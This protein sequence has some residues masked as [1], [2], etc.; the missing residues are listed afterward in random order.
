MK[1]E[2]IKIADMHCASC[3]VN[4]SI[5]LKKLEGIKRADVNFAAG[6]AIV[7]YDETK[8]NLE[9][10][11]QTI[12]ETG[13][14]IAEE[15]KTDKAVKLANQEKKKKENK[16]K[17]KVTLSIIFTLPIFIRMF[18][19]WSIPG[20]LLGISLTSWTQAVLAGV[21]VFVFG[22]QFHVTTVKLIK[23]GQTNM[24][25]LISL[26]TLTAFFY[27]L[28]AATS[29]NHMYFESAATITS[30]I[31]LGKFLELKSKNRAS[32]AMEKLMELG[33]KKARVLN[34]KSEEIETSIDE[35]KVG[36]VIL[37]KP[38]EKIP[39]DG[40]VLDGE[41]SV[42][43][44][45]LTGESM[46]VNK[47]EKSEVYGATI[48]L[49]G[50][51]K[52]KVTKIGKDTVLAQIIKTVEEAQ[53]FKAPVQRLADKISSIFVPTVVGLSVLTFVGWYMA[54]QNLSISIINAVAVL[55]ISCPCALGIA[56]PIAVM[57]GTSVGAR[58]GILIK[59][60]ESFEK[61]KKIDIVVFDKTGTL[62]K[63]EP[64]VQKIIPATADFSEAKTLKIAASL[65]NKSEH[66]LSRAIAKHAQ[67]ENTELAEIKNFQEISGQGTVG[68][69]SE[70]QTK[71]L[72]GNL[73]L[74]E[75]NKLDTAWAKSILDKNKESGSTIIFAAHG[76]NI[77]G[78][79]LLADKIKDNAAEA[80]QKIK[81]MGLKPIMLSGDNKNV[82]RIVANKLD[83]LDYLAEILPQEKQA[84]IKKIQATNKQVVFVGDG[85]N[86]APALIQADLG[87]AMGSGTDIAK[88]SGDIIIMKNDPLKIVDALKLSRKTFRVIKQNL[89]W[90]FFYNV[91]AIPLAIMGLVNPMVG[92]IAMTFSD[93]TVIGNSLRI[94]KK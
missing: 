36:D 90:A 10:I 31:L 60:G 9:K 46:P 28:W 12:I 62:T 4:I 70:H 6:R 89:F 39:L 23:K 30:L 8:I 29:N 27:S 76:E 34:E 64:E 79:I 26:G 35:V 92:A 94:Y 24:D 56:T 93:I 19:M 32:Q 47:K 65:A 84:E 33:V 87:I 41:S 55:I 66:P 2:T 11:K 49:D 72:L 50:Q 7:E 81:K 61:A 52:I 22:W 21:V 73:K 16:Q 80:I 44:S 13:Y 83:I 85:I 14:H 1:K 5:N 3:A 48:N 67:K 91:I 82:A 88:E 40:Q 86:D 25:T 38:S 20:D 71:L 45:M 69:C 42:D 37:V 58:N 18:W 68:T 54:T 43:E 53:E 63:G 75:T 77:I 51:L 17:I 57:V 74:L 59:D 15:V 78:A